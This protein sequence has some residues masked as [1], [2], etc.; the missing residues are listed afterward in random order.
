MA[1]TQNV[2]VV[3]VM[4]CVAQVR[5]QCPDAS[6]PGEDGQA[7]NPPANVRL[8][9]ESSVKR[10]SVLKQYDFVIVGASPSGCVL[11]NRLSEVPEWN[12]LLIEAGE[13]EN[14]FVQVPI[15]SA[16]LQSTSYNW[17]Y[18]AEPQ[19]YSC[20]G[21][22]D[23]RCSYPRGKGLGGSTLINYMMYVRGNKYDYDQW[24][25]AG[26]DGWSYD[27]VLP[28]FIRSEKSYLGNASSPYHG[29]G[30]NLDV[31]HLPYRTRL[32]QLF[33]DS[34]KELGVD[35]VD[36]NGESQ[37]GVSYI[38]SNVRTG[39][40]LTAYTAF[41][42]PILSRPNLHILTSSRATKVL[43]DPT[44]RRAYAVEFVRDR[45]RYTVYAEKEV[46]LTAGA[47]Q[48]P[49]LLMLSGVGPRE[50]LNEIGVPVLQDLPV[51]QTLYDHTYFTGLAFVTNTTQLS[52]HG[53]NV[54]TIENF[55]AFLQGQGPMT[56]TGGVEAVAFIRNIS[57]SEAPTP[58]SLPNIEY[59]F[60]GGSQA[61]DSGSGIRRG[62]R[63]TDH[64]YSI[65]KPLESNE[66]DVMTVNIVLLHPKSKGYMRLKSCNPLHWPRYY[67]NSLKDPADVETILR[68]IRSAMP[69][70]NTRAARS[71]G[72]KL[73]DVPLPNCAQ[74]RFDTDDYWRCAIRTQTTSIHHQM[75]TCKMG[76][77]SDPEAV[78]SP[79]LKVHG[80]ER[81]R[82]ADVGIIPYPTSGHPTATAY[83]IGE[84]LADLIRQEWRSRV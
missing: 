42:E 43:I 39:R 32:A 79:T 68:G 74:H 65:Y 82:V 33:V 50:H 71:F 84:K 12:V 69:L 7:T 70:L 38:Q 31:R 67:S 5:G 18:L 64:I 10:A 47:L 75:T 9:R 23:Q 35:E 27:D 8:L 13:Q 41:L 14:I 3:V 40:R 63:L 6:G 26:N 34:W 56:V 16:Y 83:M 37:L 59:I 78:V 30:G 17:G 49:Q 76:P 53:D 20:W 44:S 25:A 36:Y 4:V 48:T 51:G 24:A 54:L 81:L 57:T 15:F 72:T 55:L 73:Y 61:A 58:A 22:K 28:Y 62:F 52:L 11:A 45:T 29:T 19:I 2:L 77:A 60:S 80:I 46:L 1:R 66:Q 21:M